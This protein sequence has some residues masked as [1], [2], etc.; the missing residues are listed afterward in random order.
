M[1]RASEKAVPEKLGRQTPTAAVVL[2]YTTTHGQKA[3][4][5][6]N[7]TGRTA[8]QWQQLLLYDILAENEDGLWVHITEAGAFLFHGLFYHYFTTTL[9]TV[10]LVFIYWYLPLPA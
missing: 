10:I 4:D 6:Y 1:P 5:L 7:T 2:P 8:Q 3:I 9:Y